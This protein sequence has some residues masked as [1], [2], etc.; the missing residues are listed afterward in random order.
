MSAFKEMTTPEDSKHAEEIRETDRPVP[1]ESDVPRLPSNK[2][3]DDP[4][5]SDS[6]DVYNDAFKTYGLFTEAA[7]SKNPQWSESEGNK[8][9]S[10]YLKKGEAGKYY[11]KETGKAY[12]SVGAWEKAQET[13][14]KRYD[15]V[16]KFY[17]GKA[18]KEWARFKNA[19]N[20][21]A[22]D[23]E[24]WDHYRQSQKYYAKT[25]EFK[26]KAEHIWNKLG[27]SNEFRGSIVHASEDRQDAS[28]KF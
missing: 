15:S 28:E 12:D 19:E 8:D 21:G 18:D 1:C 5:S 4:P 11:D 25:E 24:R 7:D 3:V 2:D 27:K 6:S 22:S 16:T 23:A 14:A 20:N 9:Y 26:A 10:A 13:L 17:K